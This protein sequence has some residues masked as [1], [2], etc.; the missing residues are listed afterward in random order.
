MDVLHLLDFGEL[1]VV[2]KGPGLPGLRAVE[3]ELGEEA[4]KEDSQGRGDP[5]GVSHLIR[6]V[7]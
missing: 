4:E 1:G 2:D 6:G 7:L 3:I 5:H